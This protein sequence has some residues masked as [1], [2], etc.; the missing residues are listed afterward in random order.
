MKIKS[1]LITQYK[2]SLLD[3]VRLILFCYKIVALIRS[4]YS[5]WFNIYKCSLGTKDVN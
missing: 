5:I 4:L 2:K 3:I 1:K